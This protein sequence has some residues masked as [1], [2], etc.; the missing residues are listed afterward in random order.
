MGGPPVVSPQARRLVSSGA[1]LRA[2]AGGSEA[3]DATHRQGGS[4]S[5]EA[6]PAPAGAAAAAARALEARAVLLEKRSL[7]EMLK[8]Y[9][10]AFEA[11]HG[12]PVQTLE[13]I[14]VV[15]ADYN[16]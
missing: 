15:Q 10:R 1:K 7:H 9:E 6:L 5:G 11:T 8:R 16:R 12:R 4:G 2:G 14:A 13:D 3:S